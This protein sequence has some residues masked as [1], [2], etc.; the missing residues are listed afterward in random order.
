M[1][2]GKNY[3]ITEA[4]LSRLLPSDLARIK[5]MARSNLSRGILVSLLREHF[6]RFRDPSANDLAHIFKLSSQLNVADV[7]NLIDPV[8][9]LNSVKAVMDDTAFEALR[10]AL[11]IAPSEMK[12]EDEFKIVAQG[13]TLWGKVG[14]V[15]KSTVARGKVKKLVVRPED[16]FRTD[17]PNSSQEVKV[18]TSDDAAVVKGVVVAKTRNGTVKWFNQTEGFGFIAPENGGKDVFVHISAL[19]RAGIRQLENNQKVK[20]E[21]DGDWVSRLILSPQPTNK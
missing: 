17:Q 5:S 4:S 18:G 9:F 2:T 7:W 21:V 11:D 6:K 1:M 12:I 13:L 15:V 19:E 10:E 8:A 14:S 20:F 16:P 3:K